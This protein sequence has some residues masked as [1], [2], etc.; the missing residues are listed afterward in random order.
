MRAIYCENRNGATLKIIF[1]T[2]SPR[3]APLTRGLSQPAHHLAFTL[4]AAVE[5]VVAVAAVWVRFYEKSDSTFLAHKAF[6]RPFA[7]E[8][9]NLRA[10]S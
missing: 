2:A 6:Y 9:P 1:R 3:V 8:P 5:E 4:V 10:K 7:I